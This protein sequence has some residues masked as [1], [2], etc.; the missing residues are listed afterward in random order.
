MKNS[1][2][3]SILILALAACLAWR[4]ESRTRSV[5]A[6]NAQLASAA[7]AAGIQL[8]LSRSGDG[9][10]TTKHQREVHKQDA[11]ALARGLIAWY[12]KG[13]ADRTREEREALLEQM[14]SLDGAGFRELFAKLQSEPSA[15]GRSRKDALDDAIYR[16]SMRLPRETLEFLAESPGV[17]ETGDP[18]MKNAINTAIS[19]WSYDDP[20]LML[21][22]YRKSQAL[23]PDLST[24]NTRFFLFCGLAGKDPRLA[25]QSVKEFGGGTDQAA[26]VLSTTAPDNRLQALAALREYAEESSDEKTRSG[27][28]DKALEFLSHG[29][30]ED[31]FDTI[32]QWLESAK[33]TPHELEVFAKNVNGDNLKVD[34]TGRWIDWMANSL[35]PGS[36]DS[37]IRKL[38]SR[39]AESDYQAAADWLTAT[40]DGPAKIRSVQAYAA[41]VAKY[42]PETATQWALTLPPGKD[43]EETL[44]SIYHNWP[45]KDE[46]STAAAEAFAR[47]HG[48]EAKRDD[49]KSE[50]E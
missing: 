31:G 9:L 1:I 28:V 27:V 38:V 39:W 49:G 47:Q 43:R 13:E 35:P 15:D 20:R 12:G 22:W 24:P 18:K 14:N 2:G 10:R 7:L 41:T 45:K 36:G 17:F 5:R 3:I 4:D 34:D 6:A 8:D 50:D 30:A 29:A 21:A 26:F 33:L 42:E 40:P 19:R 37:Q 16:F 48:I 32:A 11:A 25:L 23:L 46:A 44:R